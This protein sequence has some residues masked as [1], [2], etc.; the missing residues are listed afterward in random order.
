M[1]ISHKYKFI[2][3]KTR[4]TAGSSVQ[5]YLSHLCD[6][7]DIFTPIDRPEQPYQPRNYKGLF[8]PLPELVK[9]TKS[10]KMI[11]KILGR[12]FTLKKFQSHIK[13]IDIKARISP[14]IWNSYYKFSIER[15]PWDKVLSYYY[16][17]KQ[18]YRRY[19]QNISFDDFLKTVELSFN[20]PKYTD[21]NDNI[22]VDRVIK[23]EN[24]IDELREIFNK[25]DIPFN[26]SIGVNEKSHYRTDRRPYQEVY[27]EEQKLLIEKLFDK[28]I[29]MHNYKF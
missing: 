28:E 10:P 9:N 20:Y 15:N 12:F 4:K 29:K 16:F 7:L 6:E 2:F 17:A 23:Y 1:I 5:I 26:G 13:A 22:I 11:F 3:I 21:I 8:N 19:N 24:L 14:E 27:T 25:L 18:R